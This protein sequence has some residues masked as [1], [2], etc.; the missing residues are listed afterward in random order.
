MAAQLHSLA[1]SAA[2]LQQ[3]EQIPSLTQEGEFRGRKVV[4]Q[5]TQTESYSH[6]TAAE[7][8]AAIKVREAKGKELQERLDAAIARRDLLKKKV[9]T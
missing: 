2:A 6:L 3:E 9:P 5:G 8:E 7:L 4:S 1:P